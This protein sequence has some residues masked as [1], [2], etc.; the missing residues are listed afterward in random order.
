M[1]KPEELYYLNSTDTDGFWGSWEPWTFC[2]PQM[3]VQG[4]RLRSQKFTLGGDDTGLDDIEL[5]CDYFQDTNH[6]QIT[7]YDDKDGDGTYPHQYILR[8]VNPRRWGSWGPYKFC[9]SS[10]QLQ[11]HP[12]VV[13]LRMKIEKPG[14]GDDTAANEVDLKCGADSYTNPQWIH[15]QTETDKGD[16]THSL[17]CP[18]GT[19][20]VGMQVRSQDF[21]GYKDDTALN[22][23]RVACG[24]YK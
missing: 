16:V 13:G 23:L 17:I 19:A 20:V 4:Y 15:A 2:P 11:S 3:H 22:G 5:V 9:K 1:A 18:K 14:D 7:K 24:I 10:S 21:Q 8:S 6:L 12:P